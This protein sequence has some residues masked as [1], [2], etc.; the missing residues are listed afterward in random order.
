MQLRHS[1]P[2]LSV[3][4]GNPPAIQIPR[5]YASLLTAA[6]QRIAVRPARGFLF[7]CLGVFCF[8]F[9]QSTIFISWTMHSCVLPILKIKFV[10]FFL[11]ALV[12][13]EIWAFCVISCSIFSNLSFALPMMFV[14]FCVFES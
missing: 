14:S 5:C 9:L 8:C 4:G 3:H 11:T 2:L 10:V 12:I 7:V 6:F 13:L 1:E